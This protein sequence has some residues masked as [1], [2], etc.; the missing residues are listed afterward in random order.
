MECKH[1]LIYMK[2]CMLESGNIFVKDRE[3]F[4]LLVY[5]DKER[6]LYFEIS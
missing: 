4:F 2:D 5:Q 6:T 3:S 1:T